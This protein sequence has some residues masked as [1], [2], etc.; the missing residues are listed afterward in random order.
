MTCRRL[1]QRIHEHSD[2][3][4]V[5]L[6]HGDTTGH[7]INFE[8]LE[9]MAKDDN[10]IRLLIKEPLKIQ[11]TRAYNHLDKNIGSLELKLYLFL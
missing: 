11:K 9:I 8:K 7:L 3:N 4:S 6:K 1:E 5:L 10:K 2:P